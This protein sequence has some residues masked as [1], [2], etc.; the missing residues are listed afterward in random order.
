[1]LRYF[2]KPD[3]Y[4]ILKKLVATNVIALLVAILILVHILFI[5]QLIIVHFLTTTCFFFLLSDNKDDIK[6]PNIDNHLPCC[7]KCSMGFDVILQIRNKIE[8]KLKS[9]KVGTPM[10]KT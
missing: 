10:E 5:Q 4:H 8:S 2:I 1:M 3:L 7:D 9:I 6:C